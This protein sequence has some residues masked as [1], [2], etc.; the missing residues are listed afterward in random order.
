MRS[1]CVAKPNRTGSSIKPG[2][3]IIIMIGVAIKNIVTTTIN[4]AP[5]APN[6]LSINCFASS[7][8]LAQQNLQARLRGLILMYYSNKYHALLV[9]TGN[10]SELAVGYCTLYGDTNGGKNVPGDIYKTELYE[11]CNWMY[12]WR[13]RYDSSCR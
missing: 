5:R 1:I 13:P 2:A 4:A 9:S 8:D 3:K 12:L 11:V 6:I 7:T 10:K